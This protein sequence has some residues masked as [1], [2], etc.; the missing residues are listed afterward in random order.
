MLVPVEGSVDLFLYAGPSDV[1]I[2][3]GLVPTTSTIV[4]RRQKA[5]G[6]RFPSGYFRFGED[7]YYCLKLLAAQGKVAYSAKME[8]FCGRG[9]NIFAG[10]TSGSEGQR[11]C[12]IDEISFRMDALATLSLT[13]EATRHVQR[14]LIEARHTLLKQGLWRARDDRG[15][16]L[17]RT[18]FARPAL[19]LHLPSALGALLTERK[20]QQ[21]Q[22]APNK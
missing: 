9:V 10:N 12:L 3:N 14:K 5:G 16:W 2:V 7:Q 13:P 19:F 18:L 20:L 8:V 15:S 6:A 22:H 11:L 4:H 17:R 21:A 1:V